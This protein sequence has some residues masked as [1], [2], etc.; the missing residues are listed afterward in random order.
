M[1]SPD[2]RGY[3]LPGDPLPVDGDDVCHV[4]WV[5]NAPEYSRAVLGQ[6]TELG[7][8]FLWA[9]DDDH[10]AVPVAARYKSAMARTQET[11]EDVDAC[12]GPTGVPSTSWSNSWNFRTQA[13]CEYWLMDPIRHPTGPDSTLGLAAVSTNDH[14]NFWARYV[15]LHHH[16]SEPVW[17]TDAQLEIL[18]ALVVSPELT[19]RYAEMTNFPVG[20]VRMAIPRPDNDFVSTSGLRFN[21]G[22]TNAILTSVINLRIFLG[23]QSDNQH[24]LIDLQSGWLQDFVLTVRAESEP[25]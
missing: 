16:F 21:A 3:L 13:D 2:G 18:L 14:I 1:D 8:W 6:L 5:P 9:K 19:D 20:S 4:V 10:R 12:A 24:D 17:I 11:W 25:W 22:P 15:D 7:K 23:S